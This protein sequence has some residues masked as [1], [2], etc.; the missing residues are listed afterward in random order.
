MF[1]LFRKKPQPTPL[2]GFLERHDAATVAAWLERER[3]RAESSETFLRQL[4]ASCTFACA[5]NF[6]RTAGVTARDGLGKVNPDVIAFESLAFSIY[7]IRTYHM[8]MPE[9][10]FEDEPEALVDAYREVI[11]ILRWQAEKVTGWQVADVWERRI[12]YHFQRK[13]LKDAS[14]AFVGLLL[15]M[16]DAQT[17]AQDYGRTKLDLKLNIALLAGVTA[18]TVSYPKASAEA[19]QGIISEFTLID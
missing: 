17:P 3:E 7:A 2:W 6:L 18:F 8:P 10:P 19:I 1:S 5:A 14:Q 4:I 12:L 15:T 9:D 16:T 13:D 11:A